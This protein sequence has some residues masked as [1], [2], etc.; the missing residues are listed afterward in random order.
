MINNKKLHFAGSRFGAGGEIRARALRWFGL[1]TCLGLSFILGGCGGGSSSS[2]PTTAAEGLVFT[3]PMDG[4]HD[5]ALG[6]QVVVDFPGTVSTADASEI[7]LLNTS[8]GNYAFAPATI[9]SGEPSI[10]HIDTSSLAPGTTYQVKAKQAFQSANTHFGKGQVLFSFK[11]MH[12][13]GAPATKNKQGKHFSVVR[14]TPS[15]NGDGLPFV[16]INTLHIRLSEAVNPSTVQQ[17]GSTPTFKFINESTGSEVPGTLLAQGRYISFDPNKHLNASDQ[18]KVVLTDSIHSVFGT[19]LEP[20]TFQITPESAGTIA[21]LPL[22]VEPNATNVQNLPTSGISGNPDNV[23]NISSQLIGSNQLIASDTPRGGV[24]SVLADSPKLSRMGLMIATIKKGSELDSSSLDLKLDN[25]AATGLKS[26]TIHVRFLDAGNVAFLQNPYRSDGPVAVRL[27]FD[28]AISAQN[29]QGNGA[30]NQTVMGVQAAGVAIVKNKQLNITT[31]GAFPIRVNRVGTA[32]VNFTLRLVAKAGTSA[33]ASDTTAPTV[34]AVYPSSCLYASGRTTSSGANAS[35][36]YTACNQSGLSADENEVPVEASPAVTFSEPIDPSTLINANGHLRLKNNNTGNY[37][38]FTPRLAGDTVVLKPTSST[39]LAY[40][41]P[42][43]LTVGSQLTDLSGNNL[44]SGPLQFNFT[45]APKAGSSAPVA[46]PFL[47]AINPG[48]PCALS[49]TN[50][51]NQDAGDCAGDANPQNFGFFRLA[52]NH[53]IKGEFSKPVKVSTLV[54][55]SSCLDSGTAKPAGAS[56]AVEKLNASGTCT[57]VVSGS[58]RVPH[59]A[60]AYTRSF[61]FIPQGRWKPNTTYALVICGSKGSACS[62][63]GYGQIQGVD[64]L[65]LNTDPIKG[66]YASSDTGDPDILIPFKDSGITKNFAMTLKASPA[67]DTNGN[68]RFDSSTSPAENAQPGNVANIKIAVVNPSTGKLASNE[69]PQHTYLHGYIAGAT[70][71]SIGK[72]VSCSQ[73]RQ[74]QSNALS[75]IV[76]PNATDC[77]GVKLLPGGSLN[78]TSMSFNVNDLLQLNNLTS[79]LDSLLNK[80]LSVFNLSG[81]TKLPLAKTGRILMRVAGTG[82]AT[83]QEG[84]LFSK[85]SY[86]INGQTYSYPLCFAAALTL[87]ENAPDTSKILTIPQQHPVSTV[88]GPVRF[89]RNGRMVIDL[90]NTNLISLKASVLSLVH[91]SARIKPGRLHIQLTGPAIHGG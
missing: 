13:K 90:N 4:Q 61:R 76:G 73:A 63:T 19:S 48:L 72:P 79:L 86:S 80:F 46:P 6:S 36:G 52:A 17:G 30:F 78:L 55:A 10:V 27:H 45:T 65:A 58:I 67:S 26:G 54:A 70:P 71:I 7:G 2:A 8:T 44:A 22:K 77:I 33:P 39:G 82:N 16:T 20:D 41:T 64:G 29:A 18:Y 60:K 11:T 24:I 15:Q 40:G 25:V 1:M 88:V 51:A 62:A 34:T 66:S 59:P 91:L 75:G 5:V 38:P 9:A 3:Y 35:S 43:T 47:T 28:A 87:K 74:A 89:E 53:N 83:P 14:Y 32:T 57:G 84:Y 12:K 49:G 81:V 50:I 42:Y 69:V 23:M 31:V 56:I 21:H 37:V 68:G 85:C